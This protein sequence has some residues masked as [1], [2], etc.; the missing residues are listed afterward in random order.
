MFTCV[1]GREEHYKQISLACVRIA[2][3][4]WTTLGLPQLMSACA[5][6]VYTAQAPGCS[7]GALSKVGPA[8][9]ALPRSKLLR[10]RSLGTL[11]GHRLSWACVLCLSQVQAAQ[12]TRC[13][14]SKCGPRWAVHLNH[15][16]SPSCSVSQVP[17]ESASA[18]VPCVSSGEL[19]SGCHPPGE[20]QP[21][22]FPGR[23][24]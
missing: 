8:F 18:G 11:Q 19:I 16:S 15:L 6:R 17:H 12:V 2:C 5:S 1:V 21:F 13:L 22:R 9:G 23:H 3:S 20:C 24:C 4:V 7:A 10:F 14:V